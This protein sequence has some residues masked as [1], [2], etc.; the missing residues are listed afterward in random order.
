MIQRVQT[1][2]MIFIILLGVLI[3][4]FPILEITNDGV[5]YVMN[6]YKTVLKTDLTK[7]LT[8]NIGVGALT[9]LILIVSLITILAYKKRGL[10]IK[11]TKLNILL[12]VAKITAIFFYLDFAEKTINPKLVEQMQVNYNFVVLVPLLSL[13]LAFLTIKFIK[14]DED[15]IKATDRLR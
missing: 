10:Q 15:L 7:V 5:T 8:K 12:I 11:L 4:V 1:L 2:L 13:I 3:F 9:G 14:K 6:A